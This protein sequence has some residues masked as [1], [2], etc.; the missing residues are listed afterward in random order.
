[1]DKN[2]SKS[3]KIL[4]SEKTVLSSIFYFEKALFFADQSIKLEL[5]ALLLITSKKYTLYIQ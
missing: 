1:M 4:L 5:E 3:V 2:L